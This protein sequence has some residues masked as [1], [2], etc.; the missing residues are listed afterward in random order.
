MS[1]ATRLTEQFTG[2]SGDDLIIYRDNVQ[3]V[4]DVYGKDFTD[5]LQSAN[6]LSKQFGITNEEA[7]NII[8]DGFV[9]GADVS[10]NFL[11][12]VKEVSYIFS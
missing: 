7:I 10:G 11:D 3:A 1:E 4:A 2:L 5:V 6:A 8:K 12:T 9:A